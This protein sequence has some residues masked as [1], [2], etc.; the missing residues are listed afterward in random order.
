MRIERNNAH[1]I[2]PSDPLPFHSLLDVGR[3]IEKCL[4]EHNIKLHSGQRMKKY[5]AEMK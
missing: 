1:G 3:A 4:I 2:V 5:M